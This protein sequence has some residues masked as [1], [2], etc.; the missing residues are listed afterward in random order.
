MA[1]F[2]SFLQIF[3]FLREKVFSFNS[4]NYAN[5]I[6]RTETKRGG[7]EEEEEY[8][9]RA[10]ERN[11]VRK[12]NKSRP[13]SGIHSGPA[14][15][16]IEAVDE[17]ESVARNPSDVRHLPLHIRLHLPFHSLESFETRVVVRQG[18]AHPGLRIAHLPPECSRPEMLQLRQSVAQL[19]HRVGNLLQAVARRRSLSL[20]PPLPPPLPL[21]LASYHS[22]Q[23]R[24]RSARPSEAHLYAGLSQVARSFGRAGVRR[25]RP[26]ADG[27]EARV[28]AR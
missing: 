6:H 12:Q 4:Q 8:T 27:R 13:F 15:C 19:L 2:F 10:V 24:R 16:R 11:T 1:I 25:E 23:V 3:S 26:D 22:V 14:T 7:E 5:Y 9:V 28:H 21:P 18:G 17:I 20:A